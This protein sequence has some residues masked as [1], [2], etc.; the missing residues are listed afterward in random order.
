M[1]CFTYHSTN[2]VNSTSGKQYNTH[3]CYQDKANDCISFGQIELFTTCPRPH[4]FVCPLCLLG[5]SMLTQAGHPCRS[6]LTIYQ[7]IDL[8]MPDKYETELNTKRT[9]VSYFL[10]LKL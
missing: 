7:Q 10:G 3:C 9:T 6:S 1:E 5:T 8:H 2:Y 4:A